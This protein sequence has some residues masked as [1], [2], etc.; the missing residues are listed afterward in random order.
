MIS[1]SL[2]AWATALGKEPRTL[3]RQLTKASVTIP[4]KGGLI[5]ARDV[6]M[7]CEGDAEKKRLTAA[8]AE[9][10]ERENALAN[11]T[12]QTT[13]GVQAALW[14]NGL[15]K[16]RESWIGYEKTTGMKIKAILDS[17][18]VTEAVSLRV[19]AEATAGVTDAVEK[20]N[21][22]LPKKEQKP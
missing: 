21:A 12:L 3:E 13:N 2:S 22:I 16:V 18:G 11:G 20:L 9:A 10:Q 5:S 14:E 8:Q 15:A 7:A 19:V 4:K 6:F 1:H 17:A